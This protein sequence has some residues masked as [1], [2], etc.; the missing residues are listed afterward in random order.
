MKN[1]AD[2]SVVDAA[3]MRLA[4][5]VILSLD[6]TVTFK[7]VLDRLADMDLKK[8]YTVAG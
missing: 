5:H 2:L 7:D 3:L 1:I 8:I 6:D 4:R